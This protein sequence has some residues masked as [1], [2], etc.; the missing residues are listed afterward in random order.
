MQ[1]ASTAE[2]SEADPNVSLMCQVASFP[3][4]DVLHTAPRLLQLLDS[5]SLAAFASCNKHLRSL[6]HHHVTKISIVEHSGYGLQYQITVL[7]RFT[8]GG[9]PQL[10][11][12]NLKFR[13][14][15]EPAAIRQ[16]AKGNWPKLVSL[17]LSRNSLNAGAIAAL[18][19]GN[20]PALKSLN[21]SHNKLDATALQWLAEPQWPLESLD[22]RS[23]LV[24]LLEPLA[25]SIH[26]QVDS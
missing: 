12:L 21:L 11:S 17:D 2:R 5:R 6:V 19:A 18:I 1:T 22:L 4:T 7:E 16:L 15:L 23:A 25:I 10:Q 9:W 20:W 24:R 26:S 3:L 13:A 14:R 8:N